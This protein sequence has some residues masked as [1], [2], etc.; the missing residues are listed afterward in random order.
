[1]STAKAISDDLIKKLRNPNVKMYT[2]K[3]QMSKKWLPKGVAPF[4]IHIKNGTG[5]FEVLAESQESAESMVDEFLSGQENH[6][7]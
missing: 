6:N 3:R 5:T 7:D 2:V 1:M 4:D